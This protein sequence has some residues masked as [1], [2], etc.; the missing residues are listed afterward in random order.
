[1]SNC[2]ACGAETRSQERYCIRCG[3]QLQ[4]LSGRLPLEPDTADSSPEKG[5]LSPSW[6]IGAT[7]LMA[8]ALFI[9]VWTVW[10]VLAGNETGDS[11]AATQSPD[12]QPTISTEAAF[13]AAEPPETNVGDSVVGLLS[14]VPPTIASSCSQTS[15]TVP[16]LSVGLVAE[17]A[18]YQV[19]AT[20]PEF[21]YY[22]QYQDFPAM[23]AAM[24]H[25]TEKMAPHLEGAGD[26]T[27]D[28][29]GDWSVQDS[30]MGSYACYTS[31]SGSNLFWWT[32]NRLA[33][34]SLAVDSSK[35]TEALH[36]WFFSTDTG[37]S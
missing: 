28:S 5:G 30:T 11:A 25:V 18:C 14:H 15:E 21:V 2:R 9:G 8:C 17:V 19:D 7:A 32:H 36:S 1:M 24:M 20:S 37:P 3:A 31:T 26:C 13:P 16:E 34:L 4:T 22:M 29:G 12:P 27:V 35:S 33:I 6:W 23:N 10:V